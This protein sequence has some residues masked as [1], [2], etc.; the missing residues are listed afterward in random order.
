MDDYTT[1]EARLLERI[2]E[3]LARIEAKV[4]Q[5]EKTFG[6]FLAGPGKKLAAVLGKFG[7]S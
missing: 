1:E 6:A 4:D 7:G 3:R 2:E 5:A